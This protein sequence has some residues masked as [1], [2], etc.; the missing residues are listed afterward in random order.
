MIDNA[1]ISEQTII[2]CLKDYYHIE[3][4]SVNSLPLGAD[5]DALVYKADADDKSYFVKIKQGTHDDISVTIMNL[6]QNAGLQQI[7]PPVKTIRG[8]QIHHIENSTI[9]V[10]PFIP[11]NNGFDQS[12]NEEQWLILGAALRKLHEVNVPKTWQQRLRRET[13]SPKWRATVKSLYDYINNKPITGTI[14]L[15][16]LR[17]MKEKAETIHKLVDNAEQLAQK[18]HKD[19][20]KFVLCH[21]DIHAGNIIIA[22]NSAIFIVD[23]DAPIMAPKERDL[24]FIGGGVGNVWNTTDEEVI[25]Y[26]GYGKIKVNQAILAYYR[27]ERIV[28]D[29][30]VY[31]QN[32]FLTESKNEIKLEDYNRFISMFEPKGVVDI[33]F[34]TIYK[35]HS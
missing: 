11:G 17:F 10:Y 3:L 30:A 20:S 4:D 25:F 6:L 26:N 8:Q 7:I 12:L 16:L 35:A 33:A 29:I 31:G 18:L 28:E 23:W 24:M 2:N 5:A 13:Y 27:N 9:I 32:I 19:S 14:E 21:S 22:P 1:F 34:E 15:K